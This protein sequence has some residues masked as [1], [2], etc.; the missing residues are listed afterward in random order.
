MFSFTSAGDGREDINES[1]L[2]PTS[3]SSLAFF[4]FNNDTILCLLQMMLD[5]ILGN[6]VGGK[7][8]EHFTAARAVS[9]DRNI[10]LVIMTW[11]G[12]Q[13]STREPIGRAPSAQV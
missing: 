2:I 13:V 11:V 4:S 1:K 12:L 8:A 10:N 6:C 3:P 5:L 9:T 7:K